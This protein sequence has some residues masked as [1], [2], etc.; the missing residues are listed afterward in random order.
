MV[1]R[2]KTNAI[3]G[4][5]ISSIS[6][7]IVDLKG[8]GNSLSIVVNC[9]TRQHLLGGDPGI[10]DTLILVY[11]SKVKKNVTSREILKFLK[12]NYHSLCI[13]SYYILP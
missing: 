12:A 10:F 5:L 8:K 7:R 11:K 9:T 6:K 2:N 4:G 13:T 1:R 3:F